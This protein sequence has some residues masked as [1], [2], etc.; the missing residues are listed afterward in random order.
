M[1]VEYR[2]VL[3]GHGPVVRLHRND[4]LTNL[5]FSIASGRLREISWFLTQ[6]CKLDEKQAEEKLREFET[7]GET[8]VQVN[9]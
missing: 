4:K 7:T 6:N 8:R 9:E 1:I 2:F 3:D 5:K